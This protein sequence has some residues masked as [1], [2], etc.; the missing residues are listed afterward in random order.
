MHQHIKQ[1][2]ATYKYNS[3]QVFVNKHTNTAL[4]LVS[5][6]SAN[7]ALVYILL[8]NSFKQRFGCGKTFYHRNS[9]KI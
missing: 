9:V 8:P 1:L 2:T 4:T 3:D 5:L 6:I 7:R